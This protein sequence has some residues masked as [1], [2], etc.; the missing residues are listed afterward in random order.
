MG[1]LGG[2]VRVDNPRSETFVVEFTGG[3]WYAEET[4]E[5]TVSFPDTIT[6]SKTYYIGK[7]TD[8][9]ISV[10][11]N[12]VEVAN[13]P[14]GTRSVKIKDGQALVFTPSADPDRRI[15]VEEMDARYV[16]KGAT[17]KAAVATGTASVNLPSIAAGETG[18]ATF[19]V[20]GAASG[21]AVLVNPPA[22]TTGLA[23][24][25]AA[26]TGA[27]TVTV[28]AT[29]ASADAID[30]AAATFRYVWIDLTS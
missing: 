16:A 13:T 4:L 5:N 12:G 22:L 17:Q 18:S 23:F 29:N 24:A 9:V 19:T 30:Q 15:A 3:T 27:N 26:V 25:G 28:Y 20:T 14:D 8:V 1:A 2:L 10:K 11:R 6:A 21:D 7:D